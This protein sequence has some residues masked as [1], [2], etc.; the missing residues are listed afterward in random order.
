[1][2]EQEAETPKEDSP[3]KKSPDEI[4]K[5]NLRIA[6]VYFSALLLFFV[7][8]P[9]LTSIPGQIQAHKTTSEIRKAISPDYFA[10]YIQDKDV[11]LETMDYSNV[12]YVLEGNFQ[13]FDLDMKEIPFTSADSKTVSE[14][15]ETSS[16]KGIRIR[17]KEKGKN[18]AAMTISL[19]PGLIEMETNVEADE[20]WLGHSYPKYEYYHIPEDRWRTIFDTLNVYCKLEA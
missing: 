2:S 1:M 3:K 19:A 7:I 4:Q 5:L 10:E 14:E 6:I 12:T 11:Y 20:D 18:Y 16:G 9:L 17:S 13:D 8:I 15:E